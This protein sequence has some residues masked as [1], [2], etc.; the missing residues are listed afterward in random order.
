MTKLAEDLRAR[1]VAGEDLAKLQK[2]AFDA[3]GMKI[4]NPTVNLP[5]VRRTGLP[6]G[7]A[8]VFELKAGEVSQVINDSGGHYIYKVKGKEKLTLDQVKTEIH[9]TLQNE[10]TREMMDK[11]NKSFK[12]ET[13]EA[14]FGPAGPAVM[15]PPHMPNPRMVP[16]P[17]SPQA[18]P[19]AQSPAPKPN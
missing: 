1:A 19:P 6:P 16:A 2:E 14:Y 18:P 7:H 8:A 11:V 17:T 9:S 12:V 4:D 3:A 5:S 10:R 15:P 13:N